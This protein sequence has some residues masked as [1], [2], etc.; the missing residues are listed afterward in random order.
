MAALEII[1]REVR[2]IEFLSADIFGFF[3]AVVFL[4]ALSMIAPPVILLRF[5]LWI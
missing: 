2:G 5:H 3:P 1:M 4:I